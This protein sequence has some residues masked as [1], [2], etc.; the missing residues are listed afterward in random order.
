MCT[1]H[2]MTKV[3]KVVG[4]SLTMFKI[5]KINYWFNKYT[6]KKLLSL[7]NSNAVHFITHIVSAK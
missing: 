1:A 2:W 3:A 5:I 6:I 4:V 7:S